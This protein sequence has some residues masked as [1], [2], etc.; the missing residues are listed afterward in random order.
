MDTSACIEQVFHAPDVYLVQV[1]F[2]NI[3]TSA[4]NCYVIMDQGEALVVDTGA[5][6][7]E[8]AKVLSDALDEL[9]VDRGRAKWF[10]THF[11]LDHAG[12]ID[13]VV[14][15]GAPLFVGGVELGEARVTRTGVFLDALT[16]TYRQQGVALSDATTA[17][18]LG[19]E[20][21]LFDPQRLRTAFVRGGDTVTVGRYELQVVETPGHTP[22]HLSLFEPQ[23]RIL[24]GGDHALFVISP[25]IALFPREG[26]GLQAY[27]D[28][29][30]RVQ[31]LHI[32]QL[33][34]SH[35][36]IRP[37]FEQR[38]DWLAQHH[39]KRLDEVRGIVA[40]NPRLSGYQIIRAIRWN[41]PFDDWEDI[42][43]M[44]RYIMLTQG[45]VYLK[46]LVDTGGIVAKDCGDGILLYESVR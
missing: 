46:H 5:P 29:I 21:P 11:H 34:H 26:D 33:F 37:D 30:K 14:P 32:S 39:L 17:A 6:S 22:G 35:G 36:P 31:D 10:L 41:V 23:S 12:L 15:E 9:G 27:L 1:P 42:P 44:Q 40:R 25:S 28:S 43:I 45:I 38:L 2:E 20:Q 8:G 13:R 16:R 4:T 24:F 3:S 18:R 7:D 19:V